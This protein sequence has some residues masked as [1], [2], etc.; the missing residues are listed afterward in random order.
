MVGNILGIRP[1]LQVKDG[2]VDAYAKVRGEKR[3]L[4]TMI[5][6]LEERCTPDDQLHLCMFHADAPDLLV[7]LKERLLVARPNAHFTLES[8]VGAVVGTHTGP[9]TFAFCML[10]D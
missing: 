5:D 6:Y 10:V 3:S 1:V 2:Y 4:A 9:G 7:P 8:E